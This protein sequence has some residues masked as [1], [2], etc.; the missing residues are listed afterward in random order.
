VQKTDH[1]GIIDAFATP[2]SG[3]FVVNG[4]QEY[5]NTKYVYLINKIFGDASEKR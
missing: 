1:G 2:A 3:R 5:K 4:V